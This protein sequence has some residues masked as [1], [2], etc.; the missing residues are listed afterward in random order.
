MKKQTRREFLQTSAAGLAV[1]GLSGGG[2]KGQTGEPGM[3]LVEITIAELQAKMRSGEMSAVKLVAA[4]T[5]RI[6]QIDPKIRSVVEIN[7]HAIQIA[8]KLDKERK[9]GKARSAMHGIPI[10]IKDNIDTADGMK[11][12]AGSLALLDA[13]A[14]VRDAFVVER[15]ARRNR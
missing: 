8:E 14:P 6:K 11:T 4:Y 1:L 13:P 12:T 9:N 15:P 10:L 3:E 7:P 2:V 5:E